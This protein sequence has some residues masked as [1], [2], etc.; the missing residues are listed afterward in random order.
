M[1]VCSSV[2]LL[3]DVV[4]GSTQ[5]LIVRLVSARVASHGGHLVLFAQLVRVLANM[6]ENLLSVLEFSSP[7]PHVITGL[8]VLQTLQNLLILHRDLQQ[9]PL[10]RL[11]VQ[12]FLG[13]VE[14]LACASHVRLVEHAS[15]CGWWHDRLYASSH[16]RTFLVLENVG[17]LFEQNAIFTLDLRVTF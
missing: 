10:P 11:A 2:F 15:A 6:V 5:V 3:D 7:S 12:T 9:L 14:S 17:H 1:R 16:I 13:A 8:L 4:G